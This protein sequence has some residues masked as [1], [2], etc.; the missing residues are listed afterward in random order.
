[1]S[2]HLTERK[3]IVV[4]KNVRDK[5]QFS[6]LAN[7]LMPQASKGLSDAYLNATEEPHGYLVLDLTQD[8]NDRLRFRTCIFPEE[9]PPIFYVDIGNETYEAKFPHPS[10]AKTL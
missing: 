10:C 9:A 3:V 4:L 7:Q 6:H 8:T 1:M 5:E 2:R